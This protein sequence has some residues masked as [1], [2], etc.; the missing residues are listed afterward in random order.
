MV[1][2][3]PMRNRGSCEGQVAVGAH[4]PAADCQL[5]LQDERGKAQG[6]SA[7]KNKGYGR[8]FTRA[9]GRAAGR[10]SG[11]ECNPYKTLRP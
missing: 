11:C 6:I 10:G 1:P 2:P 8:I 9:A 7:A 3:K 4:G 5:A